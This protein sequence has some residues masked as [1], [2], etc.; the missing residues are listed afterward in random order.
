MT[1]KRTTVALYLRKADANYEK[2]RPK[3]KLQ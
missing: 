2:D 3:A 1:A